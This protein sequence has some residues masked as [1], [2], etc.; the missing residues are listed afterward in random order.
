M[1]LFLHILAEPMAPQAQPDLELLSLAAEL[2]RSMPLQRST[3]RE[4][5]HIK[6]VNDFLAELIRL[7]NCAILR[8]R[9]EMGLGKECT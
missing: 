5:S 9:R 1:T 3:P 2:I 6:L 4:I 7:G 8:T